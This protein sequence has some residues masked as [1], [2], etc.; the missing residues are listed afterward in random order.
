MSQLAIADIT[1]A[2]LKLHSSRALGCQTVQ[3]CADCIISWPSTDRLSMSTPNVSSNPGSAV[4]TIFVQ[5]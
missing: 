2:A 3:L 5:L 4:D 1:A